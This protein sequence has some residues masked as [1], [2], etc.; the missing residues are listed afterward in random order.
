VNAPSCSHLDSIVVSELP[1]SVEGCED[2]LREG[3]VWLHL[4]ICL[5]CGHVGCCDDSPARH[6]T[7]HARETAHPLIRSLEPGE[8]WSWCFV[9]ELAML[10]PEVTGTTRIPRSPMLS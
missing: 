8:E 7:A 1:N 10:I 4:R 5:Q 3:G 2:C 9:D 6:A